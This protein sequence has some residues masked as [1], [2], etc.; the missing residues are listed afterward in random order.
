MTSPDIASGSGRAYAAAL[1]QAERPDIVINLQGDAPFI[2]PSAIV[3]LIEK[4]RGSDVSVATPVV[5]LGWPEL[6]RL[7]E[8]KLTTP[9]SGTTCVRAPDGR[10]LWF[11]KTVIPAI[12]NEADL[13]AREPLSPVLG[14]LGLYGYRFAA[15]EKFE[16]MPQSQYERIEGLEQLRFLEAGMDILALEI[17]LPRYAM[18]GIDTAEDVAMAEAVI[19]RLGDPHGLWA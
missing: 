8:H 6:D 1:A 7:R 11:S 15:L 13:R 2:P 16:T 4:L 14:H 10:A 17:A 9:F 19:A 12:R 3:A 18:S 5:R